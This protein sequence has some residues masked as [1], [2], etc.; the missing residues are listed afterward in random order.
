VE[1]G[2]RLTL[3]PDLRK[4]GST[5]FGEP[6]RRVQRGPSGG[7]WRELLCLA[8]E[9]R[10]RSPAGSVAN[11]LAGERIFGGPGASNVVQGSPLGSRRRRGTLGC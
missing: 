4:S 3:N 5:C 1:G 7:K 6:S 9:I 10:T 2:C 11:S 8:G